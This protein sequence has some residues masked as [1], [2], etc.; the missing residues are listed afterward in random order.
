MDSTLLKSLT[1]SQ[2]HELLKALQSAVEDDA[3]QL[4]KMGRLT[5][6]LKAQ[7]SALNGKVEKIGNAVTRRM[8]GAKTSRSETVTVRLDP[9]LRYLAE[10]A[11]RSQ[12]RTLSSFIEW[13]VEEAMGRVG[14]RAGTGRDL[15][16]LKNLA[17]TIW[18]VD[19]ADRLIRLAIHAPDL[20]NHKEQR[21]WKFVEESEATWDVDQD[22]GR[23]F[24]TGILRQ[25]WPDLILF[26]DEEINAEEMNRRLLA[27]LPHFELPAQP[28]EFVSTP[29]YRFERGE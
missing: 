8:G 21:I 20:M 23:F 25:L 26:G 19:E 16:P 12:R 6:E 15:I 28:T 27:A 24:R 29:R 13:V 14:V 11:A 3:E 22:G 18:H 4:E 9:Q 17:S 5:P 1:P 2:Q 10:L 7:L